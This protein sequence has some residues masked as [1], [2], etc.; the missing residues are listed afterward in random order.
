[1]K[2]RRPP[3]PVDDHV[4]RATR[5]FIDG[6]LQ[7]RAVLVW[8]AA[9]GPGADAQR[10]AVRDAVFSRSEAL[11]ELYMTAWRC[12]IE[13]WRDG[14]AEDPDMTVIEIKDAIRR[15][16]DPRIFV[17]SIVD[18][19][20][21]RLKIRPRS[22]FKEPVRGKPRTVADLLSL[23][24][25]P[26]HHVRLAE[27]GLS[28]CDDARVWEELLD[29][30]QGALFSRLH[31]A[32]R[33]G[34]TWSANWIARV[35]PVDSDGEMDADGD[36]K[37]PDKYRGGFMP[38]TRLVSAA[39][40][41]LGAIDPTAATKRVD[42]LAL[43]AWPIARRLWAAAALDPA[44]V[45]ADRLDPWALSMSQEELWGVHAYPEFAELR[46]RRHGDLTADVRDQL[47]RRIRRGPPTRLF[48][49]DLSRARRDERQIGDAY[50]ELRRMQNA[51]AVL[52]PGS[53]AWLA[54]Y[55][56]LEAMWGSDDLYRTGDGYVPSRSRLDLD[57]TSATAF[58]E[59]EA[60]L[61]DNPY[62]DGR[63]TLDAIGANWKAVFDRIRAEPAL[64]SR[65]RIVGALAFAIRDRIGVEEGDPDRMETAQVSDFIELLGGV[66]ASARRAAAPGV[67]YLFEGALGRLPDDARMPALW[68]EWWPYAAAATVAE[69]KT[70]DDGPFEEAPTER[71]ASLSLNTAAGRMMSGY[72][73]LFPKGEDARTAFDDP[74]L[75]QARDLIVETPGE[76]GRQGLYR[77]LL[78]VQFLNYID[79]AWTQ[80]KLLGPLAAQDGVVPELWD[81]IARIGLLAPDALAL[82]SA[83]MVR[84]ILDDRL[85]PDVRSRLAERLI[86]PV[87]IALRDGTAP[88]VSLVETEQVLRLGGPQVRTVCARALTRFVADAKAPEKTFTSGVLP[89]LAGGWPRDRSVQSSEVADG[90]AALPAAA[91]TAF[92]EAV[93]A[94][95]DYLM[96][97]DV[98]SL[99]EYRLYVREDGGGRELKFP[100]TQAEARSMLT[101]LDRTIGEEEGAV[102]PHDLDVAL[103]AMTARWSGAVK[104]RRFARLAALARR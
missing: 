68:L 28:G 99:W 102:I 41:R 87:A 5:L 63:K 2:D 82:I 35:Y 75:A 88:P 7:D 38:I 61:T 69:T 19:A 59:I 67:A 47:E 74:F 8:A 26:D 51:G 65:G 85:S 15:G 40:S 14:T 46:S 44:V 55:A 45:P 37:D 48:R 96:P 57:L 60:A 31:Q 22:P 90:F 30:A 24:L 9:L 101:L 20:A 95:G 79:P 53:I 73:S 100:R 66:P 93:A 32:E 78:N 50:A 4:R 89:I 18:L 56:D 27:I 23:D 6:R 97:F 1:M 3:R 42:G 86:L 29:R 83:E 11:P 49:R 43:K 39:L 13:A 21:P 77:L 33:L 98:W 34:L 91:D 104:D 103:T 62:T 70:A 17:G 76:G 12:V 16:V 71:L 92:S 10:R 80:A 94:L 64:L 54:D 25:E 81:A 58:A 72:F 36:D 52:T 84:R